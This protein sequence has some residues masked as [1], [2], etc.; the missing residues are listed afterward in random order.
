MDEYRKVKVSKLTI[1]DGQYVD[2]VR[3]CKNVG[4]T[5]CFNQFVRECIQ[6]TRPFT[7]H[8]FASY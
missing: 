1:S 7:F 5:F 8:F 4:L 2:V 6:E 3:G